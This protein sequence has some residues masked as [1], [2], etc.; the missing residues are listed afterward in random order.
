MNVETALLNRKSTRSFLDKDVPIETI[1]S[2]LN[3]AKTAPSGVNTQPWQVAV[4]TGKSKRSIQKKMEDTFR[5]G[6]KGSM[7]YE[8]YPTQWDGRYKER[9]KAC[10]L[11][12][13]STL[14]IKR[15]DKQRQLDQWAANYRAFD[16]PVMLLFFIDS[17]LEK[18]SYIDYG[19]FLQSIMLAAVAEGLATCP[20]AALGEYP[21]IVRDELGYSDDVALVCGM[22]L[23]YEDESNIINSYRTSRESLDEIVKYFP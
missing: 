7:D 22:A 2:I 11:L 23:G 20:Q 8:Y 21:D 5:S 6:N 16:A 13:Y 10:G 14:D 17:V 4:V 1:N 3:Q 9:R 18:G 15:E 19:M 12:M